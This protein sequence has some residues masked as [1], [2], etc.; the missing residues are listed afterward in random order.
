M[1]DDLGFEGFCKDGAPEI[2]ARQNLFLS[3][4]DRRNRDFPVG[5]LPAQIGIQN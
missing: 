5:F 4:C 2:T 3:A 1:M